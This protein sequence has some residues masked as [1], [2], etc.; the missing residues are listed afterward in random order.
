MTF[1]DFASTAGEI[2]KVATG[3]AGIAIL[4][5]GTIR[6]AYEQDRDERA[7]KKARVAS[8]VQT[9]RLG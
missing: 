1:A 3:I 8:A 4:A 5:A 7:A 9:S 6:F 2:G